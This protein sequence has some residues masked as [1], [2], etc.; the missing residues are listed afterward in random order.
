M[1]DADLPKPTFLYVGIARAGSTWIYQILREHPQVFVP[2]AKD[3]YFF[4]KHFDR[5]WDWYLSH[6]RGGAGKTAVGELSH[7]YYLSQEAARRI[8]EGLPGVKLICCLR[9]PVD[10]L[11]S[12]YLFNLGTELSSEL[13]FEQYCD[14][15]DIIRQVEY[16]DRLK[17]FF[18]LFPLESILVVFFEDLKRD[19]AG[20]ART[21]YEFLGITSDFQPPSLEQIVNPA[22][23]PRVEALAH[24]AYKVGQWMRSLGL[25]NLVGL[26]KQKPVVQAIL[27]RSGRE[28]L[29]V[30]QTARRRLYERCS[31]QHDRLERLIGRRLPPEWRL[32]GEADE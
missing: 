14:R 27:Y 21:I 16:Y 8:C 23:K 11:R 12:G 20:F 30:P 7:D 26:I 3:L 5:G 10:R 19:A 25:A 13:T 28:E 4:D 31:Q 29:R 1:T 9:E 24:L 32:A 2:V 6:F 15:A 22:R 17:P 18:D